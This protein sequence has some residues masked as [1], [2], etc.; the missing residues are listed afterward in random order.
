MLFC[1]NFKQESA[2]LEHK[3][4]HTF[5]GTC[6][7]YQANALFFIKIFIKI[8]GAAYLQDHLFW[9]FMKTG[10]GSV[11]LTHQYFF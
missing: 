1:S 6:Y 2:Y 5:L 4:T 3:K 7:T 11:H 8:G 9:E 10:F